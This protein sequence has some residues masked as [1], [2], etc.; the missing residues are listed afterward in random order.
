VIGASKPS[1]RPV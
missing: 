1:S